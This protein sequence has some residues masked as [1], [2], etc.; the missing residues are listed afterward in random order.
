M[1]GNLPL[2]LAEASRPLCK[3]TTDPREQV[4]KEVLAYFLRNPEA[5]DSLTGIARWRLMEEFVQRSVQT[6]EAALNWLL[7]QGY[8]SETIRTGS[9]RIFQLNPEKRTRAR[10]FLE[11]QH[12]GTE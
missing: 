5:A 8:L 9:E 3:C 12:E 4:A 7:E 1:E 6:T 10:I 2:F 11:R